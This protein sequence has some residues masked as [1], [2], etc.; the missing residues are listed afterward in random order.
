MKKPV[1]NAV[2]SSLLTAWKK[3]KPDPV[4]PKTLLQQVKSINTARTTMAESGK[5]YKQADLQ[6]LLDALKA[7]AAEVESQLQPSL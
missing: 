3:P 5:I 7:F 2:L 4:K 6:K 1:T